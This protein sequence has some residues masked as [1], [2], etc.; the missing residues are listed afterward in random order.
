MSSATVHIPSDHKMALASALCMVRHTQTME[1][2]VS[3][4][5]AQRSKGSQCLSNAGNCWSDAASC[6]RCLCKPQTGLAMLQHTTTNLISS[7]GAVIVRYFVL[8]SPIR[9]KKTPNW[10]T[11]A[12]PKCPTQAANSLKERMFG[13]CWWLSVLSWM[14][15]N[16]AWCVCETMQNILMNWIT[17]ISPKKSGTMLHC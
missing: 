13:R 9:K 12:L 3:A 15:V 8:F 14:A 2:R 17:Y 4:T 5:S 11:T 16:L 1:M 6:C 10:M 7:C